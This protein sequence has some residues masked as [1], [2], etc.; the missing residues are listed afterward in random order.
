MFYAA[1]DL[2]ATKIDR[3]VDSICFFATIHGVGSKNRMSLNFSSYW[4]ESQQIY[5]RAP[6][7]QLELFT[8]PHAFDSENR[9]TVAGND[10]LKV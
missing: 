4:R 7:E 9:A 5:S 3:D 6:Q 8:P 10:Y 2:L 1:G